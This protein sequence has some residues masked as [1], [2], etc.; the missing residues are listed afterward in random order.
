MQQCRSLAHSR[1]LYTSVYWHTRTDIRRDLVISYDL[2]RWSLAW[3][4]RSRR[5][6]ADTYY[7]QIVVVCFRKLFTHTYTH[8]L[9]DVGTWLYGPWHRWHALKHGL[10][11]FSNYIILWVQRIELHSFFARAWPC[12][13]AVCARRMTNSHIE[14]VVDDKPIAGT[15]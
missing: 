5:T 14:C 12:I 1:I 15:R 10:T 7:L 8:T 2:I 3:W 13:G 6:A 11:H 9:T 4:S